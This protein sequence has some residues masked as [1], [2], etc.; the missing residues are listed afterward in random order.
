MTILTPSTSVAEQIRSLATATFPTKA[1]MQEYLNS[2]GYKLGGNVSEETRKD[3]FKAW[4]LDEDA[5]LDNADILSITSEGALKVTHC[6]YW[7][8]VTG[9]YLLLPLENIDS[10]RE[11]FYQQ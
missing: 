10:Y 1:Q 6:M 4:S 11:L 3:H 8:Q 7:N 5:K 2:N 9:D